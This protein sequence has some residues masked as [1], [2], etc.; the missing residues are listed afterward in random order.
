MSQFAI[1]DYLHQFS[2]PT[3]FPVGPVNVY[4]AEGERRTLVDTSPRYQPPITDHRALIQARL[5]FHEERGRRILET[6]DDHY[7][8]GE[9]LT[10]YQIAAILFPELDPVSTFLTISEIIGHLQWLEAEGK[11]SHA[12]RGSAARWTRFE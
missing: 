3:P 8:T 9:T 5:A 6:L 7:L 10:A 2:V 12:D 4:L 1:P 11:V